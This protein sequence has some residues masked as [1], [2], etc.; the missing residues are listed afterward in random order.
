ME[1]TKKCTIFERVAKGD[2]NPGSLDCES[3]ILA[4]SYRAPKLRHCR[5][6]FFVVCYL[7]SRRQ[8]LLVFAIQ[9]NVGVQSPFLKD[10]QSLTVVI[11]YMDN[12]LLEERNDLLVLDVDQDQYSKC[13]DK[14]LS[15]CVMTVTDPLPKN[16]RPLF[17]HP[18]VK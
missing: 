10:V 13:V 2:S 14:L 12:Q 5:S 16:K 6:C 1:R 18:A 8:L 9:G 17:S 4:L 11:Q 3:G 15:K 7:T